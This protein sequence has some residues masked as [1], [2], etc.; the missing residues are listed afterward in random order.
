MGC[1]TSMNVQTKEDKDD[2]IIKVNVNNGN[3][4]KID[5]KKSDNNDNDDEDYLDVESD[6]KNQNG[7]TDCKT[8]I[9]NNTSGIQNMN[10]NKNLYN[11]KSTNYKYLKD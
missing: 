7:N 3:K 8:I 11:Y 5:N 10:I 4:I 6:R 1:N 9:N 2:R